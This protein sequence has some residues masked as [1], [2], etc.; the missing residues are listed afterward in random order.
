[1]VTHVDDRGVPVLPENVARGYHTTIGVVVGKDVKITCLDLRSIENTKVRGDIL[2]QLFTIYRFQIDVTQIKQVVAKA[3]CLMVKS[4]S[5]WQSWATKNQDKEL[6]TYVRR[7]WPS[8]QEEDWK[9]FFA[10]RTSSKFDKLSAWERN[11][12]KRMW[13]TTSSTTVVTLK[14][15]EYGERRTK[16]QFKLEKR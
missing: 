2:D 8:I 5:T 3:M 11:C 7:R 14:N 13:R 1:V 4:L 15:G 12:R 16:P 9:L 10:S 6:Q